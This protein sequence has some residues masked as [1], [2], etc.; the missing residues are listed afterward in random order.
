M[1][2]RPVVPVLVF[3][4]GSMY[5]FVNSKIHVRTPV[6]IPIPV[7]L[8][9]PLLV[10][11]QDTRFNGFFVVQYD[12]VSYRTNMISLRNILNHYVCTN[13]LFTLYYVK[14]VEL[15]RTYLRTHFKTTKKWNLLP[16]KCFDFFS[17]KKFKISVENDPI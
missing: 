10:F 7:L 13:L 2:F 17:Q 14:E 6:G 12:K 11:V 8:P 3:V 16:L 1:I 4:P 5:F 9:V 15:N